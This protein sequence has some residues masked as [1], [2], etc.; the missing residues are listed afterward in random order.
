ML[1]PPAV[2]TG[3]L[4]IITDAM[5]REVTLDKDGKATGV[6]YIDKETGKE[7]RAT[8]RVVMLAASGCESAR[9][10]LNSKSAL[11]P[12]GLA[13]GS[14]QSRP[15]PHGH[16]WAAV[17]ERADSRAGKLPAAQRG[18]RIGMHMYIAVVALQGTA[19]RASSVLRAATTSRSAAAGACRTMGNPAPDKYT[20]GIYGK[21][22]KEDARRYYGCDASA[23]PAAA[24]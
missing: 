1:L 18:R 14:R 22:F 23:S 24:R 13:N 6:H 7:E 16:A 19:R 4:D 21:K 11:F 2:E 15:I 12:N 10:L 20:G 17:V 8:A 5:V 3:N 9:I